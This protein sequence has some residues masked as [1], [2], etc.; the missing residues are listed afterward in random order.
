MTENVVAFLSLFVA[1]I[2]DSYERRVSLMKLFSFPE[3]TRR[4][5]Q[6]GGTC[7]SANSSSDLFKS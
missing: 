3:H 1:L 4:L 5:V 7:D 2:F 6:N